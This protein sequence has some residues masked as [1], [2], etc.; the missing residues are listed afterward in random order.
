MRGLVRPTS[1]PDK[2]GKTPRASASKAF[3]A[4]SGIGHLWMLPAK[5]SR[6]LFQPPPRQL[7]R[8]EGD[9]IQSV[10]REGQ[11]GLIDAREG[12]GG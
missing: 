6:Q 7:S 5:G 1:R 10:D 3:L 12:R 8:Q 2:G 11:L 4:I 9:S